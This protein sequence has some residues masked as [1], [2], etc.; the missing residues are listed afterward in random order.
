MIN[1]NLAD[2]YP[3]IEKLEEDLSRVDK[4]ANW[5]AEVYRDRLAT[6]DAEAL[7]GL[8]KHLGGMH[9]TLGRAY[10]FAFLN[11]STQTLD[12]KAGALLQKVKE[13]YTQIT[14]KL[15]FVEVEWASIPQEKAT[16][17]LQNEALKAVKHYLEVQQEN[18]AYLLSE[19]E[20]QIL[21]EKSIT[22]NGAWNRYFDETLGSIEFKLRG[23]KLSEQEVLTKLSVEVRSLRKDAALSLTKGL[24]TEIRTLTFVFNT[25]LA[26]KASTDRLRKYPTWISSRNV[27]NEVAD[28]SVQALIDAVVSR[29]DLVQRFYRL[30]KRLLGVD[31]LM[32]YDRYAPVAETEKT[33][34]WTEA[35]S[36]VR[37]AYTAF[38]PEIGEIVGYFFDKNWIDAP[39]VAGKRGGA[40]SHGA[41]PSAHPYILM[42]FTGR[43][44]DVQTLAHELGHGVHQYLAREQGI[45]HADT[46]LTTAETASVFGEML[47]FQRLLSQCEHPKD[48]LALLVSKIDDS[49]A[50]VFRQVTM[51]RFENAI[52][53]H[54][55]EKGELSTADFSDYWMQTQQAMFGNSVKLGNHYRYWWSYIPHFLHT[56]G[57]VYAYAFGE[58]LVLALYQHYQA[59]P[60]D[61]PAKYRTLLASGGNDYPEKLLAPFG[62]DLTD[63]QFWQTGLNAIEKLIEEAE[64]LA[65]D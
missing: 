5:F 18:K 9:D 6:L 23:K 50:T 27:S 56:P 44:R 41:V 32:D 4:E 64:N 14:Q 7:A 31:M 62:I 20:E 30:K 34:T 37:D 55:R 53:T 26:D 43:I 45:F 21:S 60:N 28:A 52:H 46:P 1:W 39:A 15:I 22:S 47:T 29:Y 54:R 58:L 8:Y 33:Y 3:S 63:P 2:L 36:I 17:L 48:K 51:N 25:I 24:K 40:F 42:N 19:K 11:W 49:I 38:H 65:S 59:H 12:E 13:A 16:Q 35:E 61:F 57:Y 10:T